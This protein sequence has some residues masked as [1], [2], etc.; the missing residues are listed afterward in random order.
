[1]TRE[2]GRRRFLGEAAALTVGFSLAPL[3]RALGQGAPPAGPKLPGSLQNNRMLDGW[4]RINPDGSVTAFTGKVEIGQGIVT[5]LAQIVADEL[6]VDL[7]RVAMISGDTATTPN[8][9]VTSGSRSIEESGSALRYACA[10]ARSILLD[11]AAAKLSAPVSVLRVED[12][13]VI[14]PDGKRAGYGELTTEAMLKREATAQAKPKPASALRFTGKSIPRRDIPAKVTGA[15]AYVHDVRLPGMVFGRVVRPPSP[16]ARL[17]ALDDKAVR[18]MPGVVVVRDGSFLAVAAEREEQAIAAAKALRKLAKWQETPTLPPTGR[19]LFEHLKKQ[20]SEEKI[21]SEKSEAAKVAVKTLSATFT[22]PFQAHA[23]IGPSCA[24]AKW[25][26]NKLHVWSHTQGVFPLRGEL[27]KALKMPATDI[28][29]THR[30]GS[31]C[32]GHNGA[33]DVALDAALC[34]RAT[35]GRPVKLQ[36]MREDEFAW[37]PYGS[38]MVIDLGAGIDDEGRIVDFR[39][40]LWSHTHSTR[41][42]E[43]DGTNL[44]AAWY[45]KE[46]Q[47]PGSA[48]NIPQPAGGG[49]RNAIP[50]YVFPRQ[51]VTNHMIPD[52]PVRVSALR[53]LGAYANVFA[54]ESF[55]DE[56]ALAAGVDPVEF[57]LRHLAD[58]RAKT[59]IEAVAR[60]AGWRP[61]TVGDGKKGRGIGFAKY[62]NLAAYVA[63]IA[64]VEVDPATGVVSVPRAW[65]AADAGLIVNPDG[66]SNQIEG[67]VIQSTSWTL[68]ESIAFDGTRILTRSWA[69]YEILRMPEVPSVEVTLIDRPEEKSVGAGESSQGPTVAAIANAVANATGKR[70]RDLPLTPERVKA[71]LT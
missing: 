50:L 49:D 6:D 29:V 39:N 60:K 5:A 59:V 45:L 11:T 36:W 22:R 30:E 48:R 33:D 28:V 61:N 13:V 7:A 41:P 65:A 47:K 8:E 2:I 17:L 63:V 62:K 46:P 70:L 57:R 34:A 37:E 67:G 38:A 40:E 4:L 68:R 43:S 64:D 10:E 58:P 16:R 26:K 44:L 71:A 35:R 32:Y 23:A 52:M 55:M 31:G 42:G 51:R 66:L 53:T 20:P 25:D 69:D 3:A 1:M 18:S 24:V 19:A 9:G 21:V 56:L 54:I 14:A 27:A 15:P 12:G